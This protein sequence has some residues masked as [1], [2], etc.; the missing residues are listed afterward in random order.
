[1]K[2]IIRFIVNQV[3]FVTID[4]W[5]TTIHDEQGKRGYLMLFAKTLVLSIQNF[6]KGKMPV[7]ASALT[8]YSVFALVPLLAFVFGM[9]RGFG[10]DTY[11]VDMLHNRYAS[12]QELVQ[13]V[14]NFVENYLSNATGGAFVGI[15]I[16]VL[17]WSVMKVFSQIEMSFNEIWYITKNRNY[18]R[19]FTDYISLL[20][21]IPIFV[22]VSNG[23][24]FYFNHALGVFDGSYIISP[25]LKVVLAVMPYL[26]SWVVFTMIYVVMPNTKVRFTAA[27]V[28]GAFSCIT[29]FAFKWVYVYLQTM[30]TSYNAVYGGLA[31]IPFALLF[32]QTTWMIVL[33]GAEISFAL[34]NVRNFEFEKDVKSISH[35]YFEFVLLSVT[36]IVAKR[37]RDGETPMTLNEMSDKYRIPLR[38]AS[39][40]VRRLCK[41]GIL[42]EVRIDERDAYMPAMDVNRITVATFFDMVDRAGQETFKLEQLDEFASVWEYTL[43]IRESLM[44]VSGDK[45]VMDL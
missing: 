44:S 10:L 8:Y 36:K 17:L 18:I 4:I 24:S 5:R 12:H 45:L 30:M 6:I 38:L 11:V 1:M 16:C 41:A 35:R 43:N 22:L 25:T 2:K 39:V 20:L 23:V 32:I 19:R 28:A 13:V 40:I 3:K 9:A 7:R 15:G 26:V 37:F 27:M 33:F 21:V 14:L 31:A 42:T 29:F 34:Q